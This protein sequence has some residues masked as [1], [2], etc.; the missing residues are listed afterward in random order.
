MAYVHGDFS[1]MAASFR[2]PEGSRDYLKK[3]EG[4][5]SASKINLELE[6][7]EALE[8]AQ[9]RR[10]IEATAT[11]EAKKAN[12]TEQK[13]DAEKKAAEAEKKSEESDKALNDA[14]KKRPRCTRVGP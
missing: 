2:L 3:E 10:R 1:G 5:L 11:A 6:T 13:E 4:H 12:M 9:Q 14:A 8:E 7:E